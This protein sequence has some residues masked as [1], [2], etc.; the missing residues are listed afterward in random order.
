MLKDYNEGLGNYIKQALNV[1]IVQAKREQA[2]DTFSKHIAKRQDLS[3]ISLPFV[4]YEMT[5]DVE[6]DTTRYN[7]YLHRIGQLVV[8][9]TTGTR[10]G[11]RVRAIPITHPYIIDFWAPGRDTVENMQRT[12]WISVMDSPIVHIF[13]RETNREYRISLDITN[14]VNE[15]ILHEEDR[16]GYYNSSININLGVWIRLLGNVN[17]IQK[18]IIEYLESPENYLLD[19]QEYTG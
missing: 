9:D 6:L 13:H 5:G 2:F 10:K 8:S 3:K 15:F 17:L 4:S 16:A 1:E 14:S 7:A 11:T 18:A 12:F 19:I